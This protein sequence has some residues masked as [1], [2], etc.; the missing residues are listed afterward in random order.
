M[1][2]IQKIE[3]Q[4]L[5]ALKNAGVDSSDEDTLY[6]YKLR[7]MLGFVGV[8]GEAVTDATSVTL[9]YYRTPVSG[10]EISSTIEPI[11]DTRWDNCLAYGACFDLTADPKWLAL[12]DK[13]LRRITTL[14]L[15]QNDRGF[16]ITSNEDYN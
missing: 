9:W 5:A 14:E 6:Y 7:K 3:I 2:D 4:D 1:T 12:F 8:T 16:Q 10:E 11:V 15:A 13:E